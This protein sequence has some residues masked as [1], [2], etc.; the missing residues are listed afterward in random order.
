MTDTAKT[1]VQSRELSAEDR[2]R[3]ANA[4]HGL[5]TLLGRAYARE[6]ARGC[7]YGH[8]AAPQQGS[9]GC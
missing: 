7:D 8:D 6:M 4:L 3:I 5:V 2:E 1:E 9:Q